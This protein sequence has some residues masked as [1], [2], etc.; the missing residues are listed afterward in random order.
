MG[1]MKLTATCPARTVMGRGLP[2]LRVNSNVGM[3]LGSKKPSE[4][5]VVRMAQNAI[6]GK[7]RQLASL[8]QLLFTYDL[9][10]H[11]GQSK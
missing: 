6:Q 11:V 7:T 10:A 5:L 3:S 4:P 8:P 2:R 1:A 9:E